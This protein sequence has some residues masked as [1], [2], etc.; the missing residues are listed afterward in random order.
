MKA[1]V[2]TSTSLRHCHFSKTIAQYFDVTVALTEAKKNYYYAQYEESETVRQHFK[3]IKASE[4]KWF[5][6]A[7]QGNL[8]EM[9]EVSD[10]NDPALISWARQ[11]SFDV[12][13]L[14][15]TSILKEG[16]L[17]AFQNKIVN[18]HLGL[19]PFYRGSATLFWPFANKELEHLGT[20]IHLAIAKVDAGSIIRRI[21]PDLRVSEN[22]YDITNRLIRD[23]IDQFPV[24]VISYLS[25]EIKPFQQEDIK[26]KLYRKADFSPEVLRGA[27]EY[28]GEGF[29][30]IE[31]N[32]IKGSR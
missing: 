16:W 2:L 10:I 5:A 26:G 28:V 13:C 29:S 9:L 11:E 25:G 1:L 27:L 4:Q 32:R 31:I 8:P 23:S 19:S 3:Y 15:G 7:D 30:D 20:T 17:K 24:A 6:G 21:Y 12:L 22:Y 18:L 14:F